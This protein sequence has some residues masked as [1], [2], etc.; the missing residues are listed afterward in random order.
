MSVACDVAVEANATQPAAPM[1]QVT[2]AYLAQAGL[3]RPTDA[4]GVGQK[5]PGTY[6]SGD[7]SEAAAKGVEQMGCEP[8]RATGHQRPHGLATEEAEAPTT[9]RARMAAQVRTPEGR[10]LDASAQ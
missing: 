9:A 4:A 6:D 5:I 3:E 7:D 1:A 10:A 8:S 2:V